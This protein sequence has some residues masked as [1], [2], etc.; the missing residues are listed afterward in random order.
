MLAADVCI[1]YQNMGLCGVGLVSS[2]GLQKT[3]GSFIL[4]SLLGNGQPCSPRPRPFLGLLRYMS[5]WVH[6]AQLDQ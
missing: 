1:M 5:I 3:N 4:V 6:T 2:S